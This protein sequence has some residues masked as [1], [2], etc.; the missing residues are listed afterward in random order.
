MRE[1]ILCPYCQVEAN[2]VDSK[3]V[4][5]GRSFGMIYLCSNFPTCDARSGTW[6]GGQPLGTLARQ[7]LRDLRQT[8]H[9]VL[10][11]LWQSKSI[12]RDQA[13]T[14][15]QKIMNLGRVEDAHIGQFNEKRCQGFLDRMA[16]PTCRNYPGE[17]GPSHEGSLSCNNYTPGRQRGSLASGGTEAHCTCDACF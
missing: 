4:Y 10:D 16:C 9:A 11:P 2:Y 17:F 1:L 7:E 14:L 8:C 5:N 15:L 13:Y 3:I 12:T 6:L